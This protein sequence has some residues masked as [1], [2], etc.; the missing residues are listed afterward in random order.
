MLES[1]ARAGWNEGETL[2]RFERL[3][4]QGIGEMEDKVSI[5]AGRFVSRPLVFRF[6][7]AKFA[8]FAA[9]RYG[10]ACGKKAG[11]AMIE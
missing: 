3:N 1:L 4:L 6:K 7:V 9:R 5:T 10:G 11:S 2:R 8:P